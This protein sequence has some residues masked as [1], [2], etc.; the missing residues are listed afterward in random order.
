MQSKN[1]YFAYVNTKN[2][3][4]ICYEFRKFLTNAHLVPVKTVVLALRELILLRVHA[5]K[6]LR[7]STAAL[8]S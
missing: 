4:D 5:L 8:V 1:L 3:L 7:E 6:D 2:N